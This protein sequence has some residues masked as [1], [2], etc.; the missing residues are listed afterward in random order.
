MYVDVSK[1]C[2]QIN[3]KTHFSYVFV[4]FFSREYEKLKF[5]QVF[6]VAFFS[7]YY[8]KQYIVDGF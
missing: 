6:V 3:D 5:K 4:H 7:L 2:L 8:D 1:L